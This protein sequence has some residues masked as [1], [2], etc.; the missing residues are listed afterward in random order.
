MLVG[1]QRELAAMHLRPTPPPV[2]VGLKRVEAAFHPLPFD[3]AAAH[4]RRRRRLS[5]YLL[6]TNVVSELRRRRPDPAV[7]QWVAQ[8]P[9]RQFLSVVVIGELTRV[10]ELLH[11]KDPH[12]GQALAEWLTAL[13]DDFADGVL[14]VTVQVAAAWGHLGAHRPLPTGDGLIAATAL[15]HDLTLVTRNVD[16]YAGTGVRPLNPFSH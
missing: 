11:R 8:A 2:R 9:G 15:V 10:V 7:V 5:V 12:Q 3:A 14:P 4:L 1:R 13:V 6:D 16:D